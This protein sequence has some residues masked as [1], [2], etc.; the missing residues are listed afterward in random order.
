MP[1]S[2]APEQEIGGIDQ[3]AAAVENNPTPPPAKSAVDLIGK[4][5]PEV[6]PAATPPKTE[7]AKAA[8]VKPD[9]AK[10]DPAK[11]KPAEPEEKI[12]WKTAP[13]HFRTAFERT[14]A[15]AAELRKK[16]ENLPTL[17]SKV[18]EYEKRIKEIESKPV[19]TKAD[20]EL[21]AKYEKEIQNLQ[22][23][24]RELDYSKS[25]DFQEKY[26]QPLAKAYQKALAE[27]TQ[28]TVTENDVSRQ[29]TRADFDTIRS[30]PF[31]QRRAAARQMFGQDADVVLGHIS[32][33]EQLQQDGDEALASERT[34]G[35]LRSKESRIK[36]QR[37]QEEYGNLT[38]QAQAEL[39]AEYPD[40]FVPSKE[41]PEDAE[42]LTNGY[43]L[44][45][46]AAKEAGAMTA[47]DRAAYNAVIRARAAAA[48]M[49]E[50]RLGRITAERDSLLAELAKFRES[51]PGSGGNKTAPV[52]AAED[53]VGSIA[54][55]AKKFN[56]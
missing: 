35:E 18:S 56:E 40:L 17:E 16:V 11:S 49:L 43:A 47:K 20:T 39:E 30:L 37:E 36:Q 3:M 55:M 15:E 6:K 22:S 10:A 28:L 46:K 44:V 14:A 52:V 50:K 32:R 12:D 8:D 33:M 2:I 38:K 24:V 25:K 34:S 1:E 26:V 4:K 54:D 21:V 5:A 42:A 48:P 53:E 45:D 13:K 7:P 23:T 31:G 19:E 9:A 29:A 27:A 41:N 51:D